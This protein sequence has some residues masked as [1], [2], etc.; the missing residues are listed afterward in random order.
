MALVN[1]LVALTLLQ[2]VY[3]VLLVGKARSKVL[4]FDPDRS[5][6]KA[7]SN[8]VESQPG[9]QIVVPPHTPAPAGAPGAGGPRVQEQSLS[10]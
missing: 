8:F 7:P 3:F 9:Q 10:K 6:D 1:L 2:L 4:G 5:T